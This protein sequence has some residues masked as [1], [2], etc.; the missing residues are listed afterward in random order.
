MKLNIQLFAVTKTT[1]FAESAISIEN[2]TSTLKITI[3]F[4]PNNDVTYFSSKTLKCTCNGTQKTATVSLS[5]GG[6]VSKTFT[7]SGIS[8]N[9]DGSKTVSWSWSCAT[10]TSVLGTIS[11]SGTKKLTTIQRYGKITSV[12]GNTTDSTITIDY[13]SY[14]ADWFYDLHIQHSWDTSPISTYSNIGSSV[15][16]HTLNINVSSSFFNDYPSQASLPICFVLETRPSGGGWMHTEYYDA[17]I[18]LNWSELPTISI[19]TLTEADDTMLG[20]NWGVFVQNKSKLNIPTTSNGAVGSKIE[21]VI[22]NNGSLYYRTTT[23]SSPL[24]YTFTTNYLTTSGS[25]TIEIYAYDT[26]NRQ[27]SAASTTYNVVAYSNPTI[28]TA[29]VKRVNASNV[30]DDE[31]QYLSYKFVGEISSV[32]NHN[33]K[34]FRIG[35]RVKGSNTSFT[36]KTISS[37][38]TVNVTSYTRITD[39][40]LSSSNA[41]EIVFEAIDSFRTASNPV[42]QTRYIETGKPLM[43]FNASGK[44]MAIGKVSEAGANEEKFEVEFDT[45]LNKK[46]YLYD[47]TNTQFVPIEVEVVDTW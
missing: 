4:S 43:N 7:F 45:Y 29:E 40:T 24:N 22:N 30:E 13:H 9:Q 39:W 27:S 21:R 20:L 36:Y 6:S 16:D 1:T 17:T 41:Y 42:K 26:R 2:N 31:G 28:T 46:L 12:V 10:G 23:P 19:G 11:D 35:Y 37:S 25:N 32:S 47:S 8:H 34:L 14:N 33:D 3:K 18:N 5:K 38:Y 44:A 15:G